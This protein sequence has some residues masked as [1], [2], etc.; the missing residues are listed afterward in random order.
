MKKVSVVLGLCFFL[1]M[2]FVV[3]VMAQLPKEGTTSSINAFSGTFK[4]IAMG[5]ER[6]QLNYETI[7]VIVGD[8][9]HIWHNAS[10]RCI[11]GMHVVRGVYE[12]DSGFCVTTRPDGDQV[13]MTYK[14]SGKMGA[15]SKGTGVFVGG[16]GK[17]AGIQGTTEFTRYNAPKPAAEGTFQGYNRI[18]GS[19]K[20]P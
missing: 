4:M 10:F 2:I 16:T 13:F 1:S 17:L 11:G 6:A 15:V 7:G 18:K 14:A 12:D 8:S 3:G 20:L 19:Y 5:Q 9:E